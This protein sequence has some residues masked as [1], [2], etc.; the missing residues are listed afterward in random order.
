MVFLPLSGFFQQ[1]LTPPILR[2]HSYAWPVRLSYSSFAAPFFADFS[3]LLCCFC[4][5]FAYF[6][7]ILSTFFCGRRCARISQR[8]N[9]NGID[10]VGC[11][12]RVVSKGEREFPQECGA[13]LMPAARIWKVNMPSLPI[14]PFCRTP[15]IG[16]DGP[17]HRDYDLRR[18]LLQ[19]PSQT[20]LALK[21]SSSPLFPA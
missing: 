13:V 17:H 5:C 15:Y 8:L 2:G 16:Y 11:R 6:L 21:T 4:C 7:Q 3:F 12:W 14:C 9:E 10:L 19:C 20:H 1:P 18:K